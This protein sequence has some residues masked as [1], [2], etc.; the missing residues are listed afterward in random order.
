MKFCY[1]RHVRRPE[2]AWHRYQRL[3]IIAMR[4]FGRVKDVCGAWKLVEVTYIADCRVRRLSS[5]IIL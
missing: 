4:Q 2:A 5:E 3:I 1:S